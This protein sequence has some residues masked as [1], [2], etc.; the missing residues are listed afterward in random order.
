MAHCNKVDN[1]QHQQT[2]NK[3]GRQAGGAKLNEDGQLSWDRER[4]RDVLGLTWARAVKQG[5]AAAWLG[6]SGWK[7]EL[8]LEQD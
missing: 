2:I 1:T 7:E 6:L 3:R 8:E 4:E 5:A